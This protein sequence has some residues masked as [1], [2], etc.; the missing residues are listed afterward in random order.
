MLIQAPAATAWSAL[1]EPGQ[2]SQW[3]SDGAQIDV[4]PGG[5]G[6]LTFTDRAT[7]QQATVRLR[8]ESVEPPRRF[9]F[10]WD[11]PDG[12]VPDA[13]NAPRVEFLLTAEGQS[14]R[15]SVAESGFP[16][17]QR[18]EDERAAYVSEHGKGW[19]IHLASLRDYVAASS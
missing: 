2:I 3:F 15:L 10:R 14:T 1:T 16:A 5:E 6:M 18:P 13:S 9:A 4:R 8:V 11:Y 19:D 7:S 17:L 12:A